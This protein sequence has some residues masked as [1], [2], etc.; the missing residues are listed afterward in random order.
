MKQPL[1]TTRDTN[2]TSRTGAII[3]GVLDVLF[4]IFMICFIKGKADKVPSYLQDE[5]W[6]ASAGLII[7]CVIVLGCMVIYTVYQFSICNS[8]VDVYDDHMEGKG[9]QNIYQI[10]DFNLGY[11]KI[12]SVTCSGIYLSI[13]TSGGKFKILTNVETA[14]KVYDHYNGG[15]ER[16]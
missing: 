7:F 5:F 8:Y 10:V 14:K 13:Q 15:A 1:I 16:L 9:I 3:G 4:A 11:D 6:E 12:V 2:K